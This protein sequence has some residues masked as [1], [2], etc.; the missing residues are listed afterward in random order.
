MQLEEALNHVEGQ[1]QL[2]DAALKGLEGAPS[3]DMVSE[4]LRDCMV[5]FAGLAQKFAPEQ[6]TPELIQRMQTMSQTLAL[7]REHLVRMGAITTQQAQA[8]VPQQRDGHTYGDMASTTAPQGGRA[9]VSK[10]YHIS[11]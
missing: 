9:A 2:M 4:Q 6:F 3:P 5:A 7:Q 8:L 1:L 10:L 11:G